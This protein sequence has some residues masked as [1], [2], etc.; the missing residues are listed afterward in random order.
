MKLHSTRDYSIQVQGGFELYKME[1]DEIGRRNAGRR[2]EN[3]LSA[4]RK[5]KAQI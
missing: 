2:T 1:E 5:R 3:Q 4:Q